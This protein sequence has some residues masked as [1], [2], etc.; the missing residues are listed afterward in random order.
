MKKI[1]LFIFIIISACTN[2]KVVNNHGIIALEA[3]SN[4]IEISKTNKNDV[5]NIIGKPSSVSMFDE[6]LWFYFERENQNQSVFKLGKSKIVKNN[7]LEVSFDKYGI[8]TSKRIY[9]IDDM[10]KV[11]IEKKITRK[12]YDKSSFIVKSLNSI[13]QK[14]NSPVTKKKGNRN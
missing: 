5:L 3:K 1:L 12:D 2:N 10:N 14:V 8:V 13:I 4:K 7:V 11:E 6:N 9:N